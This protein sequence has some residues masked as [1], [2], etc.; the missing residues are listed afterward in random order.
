MP[1]LE[2]IASVSTLADLTIRIV[3]Q[4]RKYK[5][6]YNCAKLEFE[7][8]SIEVSCLKYILDLSRDALRS[9]HE[10]RPSVV[11]H[12]KSEDKIIR[13]GK[14]LLKDINRRLH[15]VKDSRL[16]DIVVV[17]KV[18]T[19]LWMTMRW[20]AFRPNL[21]FFQW[22]IKSQQTTLQI[23]MAVWRLRGLKL[24]LEEILQASADPD[25]V[26]QVMEEMSVVY[27]SFPSCAY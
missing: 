26:R 8:L 7:G 22:R 9:F 19:K 3:N 6:R 23:L 17:G 10:S 18:A 1:V 13:T 24:L 5:K 27:I 20:N 16:K 4:L 15:K 14:R 21:K 12:H 2:T 11:R 25:R